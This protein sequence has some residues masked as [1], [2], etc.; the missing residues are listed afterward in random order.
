[1]KQHATDDFP[2][3]LSKL[4]TLINV[5][6][7]I[8]KA[9]EDAWKNHGQL[10]VIKIF[11]HLQS[12]E[13]LAGHATEQG[14][15]N[16]AFVDHGSIAVIGRAAYETYVLFNFVFL[17]EDPELRVFRHQVWRLCG[18]TNRMKL[19]RPLGLSAARLQQIE[20]EAAEIARL[21]P[22][23]EGSPFFTRLSTPAQN[24][25][26]Q[27]DGVRLGE[28][29]IDLAVQAGLPRKYVANMYRSFCNFSH[30]GAI[31]V[32]QLSDSLRDGTGPTMARATI[33]FCCV[34]ITQMISA[35]TKLFVEVG[36][37]VLADAELRDLLERWRRMGEA[38]EAMFE[39]GSKE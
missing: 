22:I 7:L 35:Y 25:I 38:T 21:R 16:L 15:E 4:G 18:L 37:A 14:P 29:L 28:A 26:R 5:P 9:P 8:P 2:K 34:I 23:I 32:F 31:S 10:M 13:V 1:M 20:H 30:A 3:L 24:N 17:E 6:P 33:S 19:N 36:D 27:G 39:D 11:C 12:I